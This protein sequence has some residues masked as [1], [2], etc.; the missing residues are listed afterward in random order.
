MTLG[1]LIY[2]FHPRR[3][4][5]G[6]KA[7]SITKYFVWADFFSFLVQGTGGSMLSPDN[8]PKAM[9]IGLKVYMGG[10]GMQELFIVG[11]ASQLWANGD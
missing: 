9:R 4:V 11:C 10:V 3:R 1:R 7:S 8:G 2:F 6:V 5:F